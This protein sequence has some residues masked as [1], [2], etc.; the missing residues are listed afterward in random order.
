VKSS[1][2]ISH[3]GFGIV[4]VWESANGPTAEQAEVQITLDQYGFIAL[5]RLIDT[6]IAVMGGPAHIARK[7]MAPIAPGTLAEGLAAVFTAS[8]Q[9]TDELSEVTE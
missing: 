7:T 9:R 3:G 6:E 4:S 1:F 5:G 2:V 8:G